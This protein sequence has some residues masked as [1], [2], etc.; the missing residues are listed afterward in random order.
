MGYAEQN[1]THHTTLTNVG[2]SVVQIISMPTG[3]LVPSASVG[4]PVT[5]IQNQGSNDVYIGPSNVTNSSGSN[6]GILLKGGQTPPDRIIFTACGN[7][8]AVSATGSSN[9]VTDQIY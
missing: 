2:S 4:V 6:P 9:V 7:T 1:A 8:W 3:S 5:I